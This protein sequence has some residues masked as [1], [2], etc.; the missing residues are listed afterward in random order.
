MINKNHRISLEGFKEQ[1]LPYQ[2]PE[3]FKELTMENTI[4][5][6]KYPSGGWR[7]SMKPN[8]ILGQGFECPECFTKSCHHSDRHTYQL[9]IDRKGKL[10]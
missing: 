4:G 5:F 6:G 2:C 3:C 10:F 7:S 1:D 9:F 8:H